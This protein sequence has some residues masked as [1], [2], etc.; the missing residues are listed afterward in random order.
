MLCVSRMNG[1]TRKKIY[2]Y[3]TERDGEHCRSCGVLPFELQL[4]V[5]HRDNNNT[6]QDLTNLQLLCRRCNYQKN[7]RRPVDV[8]E[9]VVGARA[10][11]D[12]LM[13]SRLKEPQFRKF[14]YHE[15]NER[16]VVPQN[17][18]IYSGSEDV[19]ISPVTANR[20]L[21]KM[22]SSRGICESALRVNTVMIR[23]K[24]DSIFVDDYNF[25]A[26]KNPPLIAD[27]K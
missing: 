5:D 12:E 4:V 6:N 8:C 7:P 13:T 27:D 3:L 23:Y 16:G 22:C 18:L 14:V 10:D 1:T 25:V 24:R 9:S 15:L 26:S 11:A 19:G 21:S 2:K 20:Y 17:D